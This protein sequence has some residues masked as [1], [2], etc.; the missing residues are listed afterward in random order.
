MTSMK[1]FK[2]KFLPLLLCGGLLFQSCTDEVLAQLLTEILVEAANGWL[3]DDED[4]DNIPEDIVV[5]DPDENSFATKIDL[6]S[7]F[8][9]IGN[10]GNYG[11]CVAWAS[12]YNL[13]TALDAIDKGWSSSQL[14]S[15]SNQTSPADLWAA[16]P[17]ADRGSGCNGTNFEPALDAMIS[18]GCA[19]LAEVPYSSIKCTGNSAKGSSTK[20]SNYRKI[21]SETEGKTL[22]NFKYYLNQGRPIVIG[23]RLGDNFMSWNSSAVIKSDTYV[24]EG[25]QHAYH[26]MVLT[27]YDDSKQAFRVRNSWGTSWGDNG[28][29]WVG[30]NFFLNNFVFAAFVAQTKSSVSVAGSSIASQDLSSGYDL[31]AYSAEDRANEKGDELSRIFSYSIYNSGTKP[32]FAS[33]RWSTIYMYYNASDA[34]DYEIIYEDYYTDEFG[35]KD[36]LDVL[37]GCDAICGGYWNNF[38][39]MAGKQVGDDF[40]ISYQMPEITGKYYLVVIADAFDAIAEANEDNNFF[41][42]TAENAK[43][44]E[45]VNGVITNKMKSYSLKAMKT[46]SQ[47][48]NTENQTVVKNGNLNAYSPAEVS[49]LL[50]SDKKSGK[51]QSKIDDYRLKSATLPATKKIVRP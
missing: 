20:L 1:H 26:A 39:V 34:N 11:T 27:G 49:R 44:L 3:V 50:L 18:K 22:K 43:P 36:E 12:G 16:I 7:K 25:M 37:E 24:Q 35:A 9:P 33:Q 19:S 6:S 15:I 21:C 45:F 5:V 4:M 32:I 48:E 51:L 47:F 28:S 13:K 38:D 17:S 10:Q 42:I 29:I 40:E 31:L 8:P 46:P 30:Y 41:F 23:A 2:L 14:A